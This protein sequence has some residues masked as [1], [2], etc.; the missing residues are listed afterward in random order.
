MSSSELKHKRLVAEEKELPVEVKAK[1]IAQAAKEID[2]ILHS[3]AERAASKAFEIGFILADLIENVKPVVEKALLME[4]AQQLEYPLTYKTLHNH[5]TATRRVWG[6]PDWIWN[7]EI[8]KAKLYLICLRCN[9][10]SEIERWVETC[11]E[12]NLTYRQLKEK[13]KRKRS[14][15]GKPKPLCILCEFPL[16]WSKK[17]VEWDFQPLC[18]ECLSKLAVKFKRPI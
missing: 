17:G 12:E 3:L 18:S 15:A 9:S 10:P 16:E 7:S 8:S 11:L 4:V 5:L 14:G 2:H 1:L 6:A 13:L